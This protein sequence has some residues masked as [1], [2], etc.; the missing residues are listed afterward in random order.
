MMATE[1]QQVINPSIWAETGGLTGLV[2]FALFVALG[3]FLWAQIMIYKMH[4]SDMREI[5][6][7]HAE[8]RRNWGELTDMRQKETNEAMRA[9]TN[10]INNMNNRASRFT[11]RQGGGQ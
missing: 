8:E 7:M 5:M 11:D 3:I 1:V 6:T 10:A 2:I 4:R 9:M